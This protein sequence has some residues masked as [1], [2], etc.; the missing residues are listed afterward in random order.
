MRAPDLEASRK[1]SQRA[2]SAT[3]QREN[4][5]FGSN[6]SPAQRAKAVMPPEPTMFMKIKMVIE[7]ERCVAPEPAIENKAVIGSE[8]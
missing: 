1:L 7:D 3:G 8:S 2:L 6:P 5:T 4:A